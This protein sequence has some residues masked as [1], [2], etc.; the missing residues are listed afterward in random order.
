MADDLLVSLPIQS[1]QRV[2]DAAQR[3]NIPLQGAFW[4]HDTDPD[5]WRLVLVSPRAEAESR[6][7]LLKLA[8]VLD[9]DDLRVI[10]FKPPSDPVF[11]DVQ[12]APG[13]ARSGGKHV[14]SLLSN[15]RYFHD[16]FLYTL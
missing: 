14:E 10:E 5:R 7:F 15:G 8:H 3:E 12:K 9:F 11:A 13:R 16:A 1:G 6:D 2:L 4:R